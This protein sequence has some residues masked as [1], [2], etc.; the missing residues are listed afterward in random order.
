M[1]HTPAAPSNEQPTPKGHPPGL[2]LLFAVERWERF[3]YYGMRGLLVLYLTAALAAHQLGNNATYTNTLRIE[4]TEVLSEEQVKAK[5]EPRKWTTLVPMSVTVGSGEASEAGVR[6]DAGPLKIERLIR[7]TSEQ[8]KRKAW[9]VAGEGFEPAKFY[10]QQGTRPAGD[11]VHY[12]VSNPTDAKVKLSVKIL[13]PYSEEEIKSR[14]Y[15]ARA[16]AKPGD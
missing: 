11:A 9:K 8:D 13:R 7:D 5:V 3:S 16:N 10:V 4:Q 15:A 14:A 12:K 2:F 1:S 6:G